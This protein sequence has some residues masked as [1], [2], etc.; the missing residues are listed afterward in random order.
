MA[1]NQKTLALAAAIPS[2]LWQ[3]HAR[4]AA[5]YAVRGDF[6]QADAS[7]AKALSVIEANRTDQLKPDYKITFLSNLIRFYQDYVTLL[8]QHGDT[9]KALEIADASRA[10]VLTEGLTGKRE[11]RRA[12]FVPQ[13]LRAA[14]TSRSVFLFYWLAPK[15]SYLWTITAEG[16]KAFPLVDQKQIEQDVL[17]YR[18]LIEEQ[19]RDPLATASPTGTRLFQELVA[20]AASL[21]KPNANVVVV[22][23]GAL[24]NLNFETLLTGTPT[25][26]YWLEDAT[27]TVAPSLSILHAGRANMA[28]PRSLL[29][30]GN[31]VTKGTGYADLPEAEAEIAG[32]QS[33]FAAADSNVITGPKAVVDA[34]VGAKPEKYS[35]IHFA[36][37]VDANAQSPLDSA[38]ILSPQASGFR[39]YAREV[40]GIPLN[41]DLVTI[42]ACRGA[43]AR[44]LSGEGLVGFAWAFFQAK[45]QNVVTS[46]WDVS[47]QSTAQLMLKFYS[48][49]KA[50]QPYAQAL[51]AAKLE[52]LRNSNYKRPY[53]WA[54]FQLYSRTY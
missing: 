54:P 51:R 32:I 14:K 34:Y 44:A 36:T 45:T 50:R 35:T 7:Y 9:E 4:L 46:L 40:A 15:Q 10:S 23:D 47:D 28:G 5:I 38:I 31:P 27:I 19:K 3:T 33:Q 13:L 29:L 22:P 49:I 39:L 18:T 20:P 41:A 12:T 8:M 43:G 25:P 17:S 42:S 53:Y 6:A 30:I 24:H 1:L 52:M 26:H 11:P 2:I 16:C 21:I 48:G 37:H